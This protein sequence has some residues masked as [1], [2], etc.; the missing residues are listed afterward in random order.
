MSLIN[1]F[2]S[3]SKFQ[4]R[5]IVYGSVACVG[6]LYELLFHD[7]VRNT[8]LFLWFGLIIISIGIFFTL[9]DENQS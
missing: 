5:G 3:A 7:P 4:K 1:K 9:K 2:K 6:L 8:V